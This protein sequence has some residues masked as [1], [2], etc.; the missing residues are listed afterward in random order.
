MAGQ[1]GLERIVVEVVRR[2]HELDAGH[3]QV[4]D[5]L[6]QV[7]GEERNV[8]NAF[9]VEGHQE[10]LDLAAALGGFLVQGDANFTIGRGHGLGCQARVFA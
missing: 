2:G 5:H 6:K 3:L 10:F 1:T 7:V 4:V 9:A 8:L